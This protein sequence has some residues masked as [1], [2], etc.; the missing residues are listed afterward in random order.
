M[1]TGESKN[2]YIARNQT[3]FS[4]FI[5][6]ANYL[7]MAVQHIYPKFGYTLSVRHS[8]LLTRNQYQ[9]LSNAQLF[10]PSFANH[11]IVITG[12]FQQTDTNSLV[13]TNRFANSRGY[14]DYYLTRMWKAGVNYHFPIFYP[15]FGIAN[16]VYFQ[17]LRGN[18]F[19]DYARVY[20]NDKSRFRNLRSV[21]GELYFDT[22]WWNQQPV[23]FGFRVS[24]LL[25]KGLLS[26]DRKGSNF[27]EFILP[28][29]L[30]P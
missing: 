12:S 17:R 22:K 16:I 4:H 14:E 5:N 13:F 20:S 23:S 6:W 19:Y 3:Y 9:F 30:L 27:F 26:S 8:H 15:D 28:V 21:G 29:S 25:D 1:P 10:L 7:P 11:S 24:H 2:L 18:A